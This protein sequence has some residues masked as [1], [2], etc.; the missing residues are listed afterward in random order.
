MGLLDLRVQS[1]ALDARLAGARVA[2]VYDA[3]HGRTYILKLAVPPPGP[4]AQ[5]GPAP[6]AGPAAQAPWQKRLLLIESGARLH[7]THFDRDKDLPTGFCLKLRKHVRTRRLDAVRQLAGDRI[8]DLVFSAAGE[9]VAHLIVEAFSGGNIILTDANYSILTLLRTYRPQAPDA[10]PVAVRERYPLEKVRHAARLTYHAFAATTRAAAN[11]APTEEM[12][13][14]APTRAA[15]R[16][17]VAKADPRKALAVALAMEPA[18]VEHALLSA[19]AG[20]SLKAIAADEEMLKAIFAAIDA[21]EDELASRL[22]SGDPM[23]GYIVSAKVEASPGSAVDAKPRESYVEFSP[24][25]F[26]QYRDRNY[27]EYATFDEAADE[28]FS[29]LETER[30]EASQAKR[31][32][33]AYKRVDKLANELKGQVSVLEDAR[34]LSWGRAT[35]IESNIAE[36]EAAITV[37]NSAIAAAVP[38]DNLARM[39]KEEKKNGNP[40]AEIIHSLQLERNEITLMLEDSIGVDEEDDVEDDDDVEDEGENED[41]DDENDAGDDKERFGHG[42]HQRFQASPQTRKALLVPVDLSLGAHANA[43]RHYE[44][45]KSAA[46]KMEKAV[47]VTDRTLKAASKRAATEAHKIEAEAVAASI[48]ARRKALWFEKFYW[49]VSSENYLVV[50]GRDAQQNE[51]LVNRYLGPADVYVHAE[52]Q[53]ASSVIV[54]NQKRPGASTHGEIP[55]MTLEQAGTFAMCRSAAWDNK[56]VTSAWWVRASQ[57]SKTTASGAYLP[58]GSFIIRGK[59]NFL[60]PT[61][62]VMGL[63]FIFKVDEASAGSHKGERGIRGLEDGDIPANKPEETKDNESSTSDIKEE[64][65]SSQSVGERAT[66]SSDAE[67]EVGG[68]KIDKADELAQVLQSE[69]DEDPKA[70]PLTAEAETPQTTKAVDVSEEEMPAKAPRSK[71]KHLSAK[72]RRALKNAKS[73]SKDPQDSTGTGEGDVHDQEIANPPVEKPKEKKGNAPLPRGKKHKLKKMKKYSDQDEEERRIA[74]AV[75]GSKPIKEE[76]EGN[77]QQDPESIADEDS[78]RKE[79]E[80]ASGTNQPKKRGS[81]PER[82]EAMRLMDEHGI[83]ELSNLEEDTL[84]T[85]NM[86]T[87]IPEADDEVQY[88]LPVCAPYGALTNYRYKVKLMPGTTK[89]GKAYRSAIVLFLKQ[90]EKD[91]AKFKQ[92]R[93]A[94]RLSPESDGIHGMLGSVKIMAPG[95]AEAQKSLQKPRKGS[96][97]KGGKK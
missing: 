96:A 31:E 24:F 21:V 15:R 32:A 2:N 80:N 53:G 49:F 59:K 40:V 71:K 60:D 22:A 34:D 10:A 77:A 51:L 1:A 76:G 7:I 86:L 23:K 52:L 58:P 30:A 35:A 4:A 56:I 84:S 90:S 3:H 73:A 16:K 5:P 69:E 82:R 64:A 61:Q 25:L 67:T 38:W 14:A 68:A 92:D 42:R 44:M 97:K 41:V 17:L 8:L 26:H 94:M 88:A 87:A 43:R 75:L 83:E 55:R 11:D 33:A 18:L 9:V 65:I 37:I 6:H 89:R 74:L 54:K 27:V 20:S 93:D 50:A 72:E 66:G 48:R 79:G 70:A 78:D 45:R 85:L 39:V 36:V 47:E 81:R 57:V 46:A 19:G 95:L 63:A 62:L 13:A 91:L 12:L 28:F 29:R